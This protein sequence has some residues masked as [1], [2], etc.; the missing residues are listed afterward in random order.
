ML[1]FARRSNW[2]GIG[3]GLRLRQ[4]S[5]GAA[6]AALNPIGAPTSGSRLAQRPTFPVT[7]ACCCTP[8]CELQTS[9]RCAE[10]E[11]YEG[12]PLLFC[13]TSFPFA[14]VIATLRFLLLFCFHCRS[15]T[16]LVCHRIHYRPRDCLRRL[17]GIQGH[18][19][20]QDHRGPGRVRRRGYSSFTATDSK[21]R[22]PASNSLSLSLPCPN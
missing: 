3:H 17:G 18:C 6:A 15:F 13:P 21:H 2:P 10:P 4:Q 9:R 16:S 22:L 11:A 14:S 7:V 20:I 8:P 19:G 5:C 12:I 1:G